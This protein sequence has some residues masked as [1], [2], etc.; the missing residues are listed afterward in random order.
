[1]YQKTL[2]IW[3][4]ML[5]KRDPSRISEI[6]AEDAVMISPV[7]HTPQRGKKITS[8]YLTGAF[9]VLS[10]DTFKYVSENFNTNSAVLEFTTTVDGLEINGVD[11]LTFNEEGL[12]TEFKVMVRP[13]QAMNKLHQKMGEMLQKLQSKGK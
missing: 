6:L 2:E 11:M 5:D 12:I 13:L 10:N 4:E 1:M 3:H 7:V 8:M 9:H